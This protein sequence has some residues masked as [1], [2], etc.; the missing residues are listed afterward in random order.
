NIAGSWSSARVTAT[1]A[2]GGLVGWS[3]GSFTLA[4]NYASGPVSSGGGLIGKNTG[5]DSIQRSYARGRV[6]GGGV[7]G[8]DDGTGVY[9]NVFWDLD[10]SHVRNPAQGVY[11]IP[12]E[13]GITG[14]G[15]AQLKSGLPAGFDP[16]VWAEDPEINGGYP[17]L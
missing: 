9:T 5:G 15:D 16:A 17:Y 6:R 1:S 8:N 12:N 4:D 11:N 14:L 13:P 3:D 10:T 7:T 2:A